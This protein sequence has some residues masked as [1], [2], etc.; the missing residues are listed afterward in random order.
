[1]HHAPR[2]RTS[3]RTRFSSENRSRFATSTNWPL[4]SIRLA[5]TCCRVKQQLD[6]RRRHVTCHQQDLIRRSIWIPL[7][8]LPKK[9]KLSCTSVGEH[10]WQQQIH[11]DSVHH[12]LLFGLGC[13][14]PVAAGRFAAHSCN[15]LQRAAPSCSF[16]HLNNAAVLR[17]LT[18]LLGR[19]LQP[20]ER[21]ERT[22]QTWSTFSK[23]TCIMRQFIARSANIPA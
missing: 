10:R 3:F 20:Q 4:S 7:Q 19:R 5:P 1:M 23:Y 21:A 11:S 16:A 6:L 13:L 14:A 22:A 9:A 12:A 2:I 17:P 8:H 15:Q 18:P